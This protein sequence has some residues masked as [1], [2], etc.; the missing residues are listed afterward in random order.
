MFK[1]IAVVT[2]LVAWTAVVFVYTEAFSW[3]IGFD[4]GIDT[5]EDKAWREI[6]E[7]YRLVKKEKEEK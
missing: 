5:G 4:Q 2:G 1:K 7:N 3:L 6:M